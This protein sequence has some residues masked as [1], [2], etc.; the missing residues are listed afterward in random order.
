MK[1]PEYDEIDAL[2]EGLS[3]DN[4]D[5]ILDTEDESDAE[6][7]ALLGGIDEDFLAE[8]EDI[9]LDNKEFIHNTPQNEL[10]ADFVQIQ[11]SL[12]NNIE[13]ILEE[14]SG[15]CMSGEHCGL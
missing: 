9:Y 1:S 12:M 4:I 3:D 7:D 13:D 14:Y 6:I 11:D 15:G 10:D 5:A 8:G 2:L